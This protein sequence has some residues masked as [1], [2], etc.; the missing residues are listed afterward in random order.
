MIRPGVAGFEVTGDNADLAQAVDEY[1]PNVVA[2]VGDC[3][4]MGEDME[5]RLNVEQ[6]AAALSSLH[7]KD[8]VFVRGNHEDENW[9]GFAKCWRRSTRPLTT[10]HGEVFKVGQLAIVGFPCLLGSEEFFIDPREPLPANPEEWLL[11]H[12]KELGVAAQT[13][14]LMHEPPRGTILSQT[15][16]PTAGNQAW[17]DAIKRFAPWLVVCGHDHHA[18]I[19]NKRWYC[20]V[21]SGTCVNVGQTDHETLHYSVMKAKFTPE[22]PSLPSKISIE[23]FPWQETIEISS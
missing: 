1:H 14:W 4:H 5:A 16:G 21:G 17:T 12:I 7:C 20:E 15:S 18:P 2:I 10:L 19:E 3:L 23:A 9:F 11:S 8:V 22:S 13:L 6:C